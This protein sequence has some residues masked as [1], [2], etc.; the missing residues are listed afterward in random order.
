MSLIVYHFG[1]KMFVLVSSFSNHEKIVGIFH[2]SEVWFWAYLAIGIFVIICIIWL[3]LFIETIDMCLLNLKHSTLYVGENYHI[4]ESNSK[5][6]V[7]KSIGYERKLEVLDYFSTKKFEVSDLPS[8]SSDSKSENI[9]GNLSV[10]IF[11]AYI[12]IWG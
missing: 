7:E 8:I 5:K 12:F 6:D 1:V 3:L 9:E 2:G 4:S 11:F 10:K